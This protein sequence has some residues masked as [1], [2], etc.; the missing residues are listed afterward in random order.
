MSDNFGLSGDAKAKLLA[1]LSNRAPAQ[2][3]AHAPI[4]PALGRP[5]VM[6]D[7]SMVRRAGEALGIRNPYFRPHDGISGA[8]A[9]IDGK[10]YDNFVSYNYIGLN[11]D[12]RVSQAAKDAVDRYGTSVSASRIVSGERPIHREFEQA[13]AEVYQAEDAVVLVSGHATNVTVIGHLVGLH[14]EQI[15]EVMKLAA[16]ES[17]TVVPAGAG[18]WLL[19]TITASAGLGR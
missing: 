10:V 17:W 7:L 9:S 6:A 18:T 3:E 4:K 19:G 11:G 13:L 1:R 8:T 15:R 14:I 2:T 12:P 5:E 16:S